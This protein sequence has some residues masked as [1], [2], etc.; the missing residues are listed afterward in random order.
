MNPSVD[1]N[2]CS[3]CR[4]ITLQRLSTTGFLHYDIADLLVSSSK[5]C[6]LCNLIKD[7]LL[8]TS[9]PYFDFS[10]DISIPLAEAQIQRDRDASPR[11]AKFTTPI[12]LRCA[13]DRAGGNLPLVSPGEL[14]VSGLN[15]EAV[16]GLYV[17]KGIRSGPPRG[18]VY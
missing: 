6:R 4:Q 2:P 3:M 18:C 10:L 14:L 11:N 13:I 17:D 7:A 1:A 15:C 16:I 9:L 8:R 12:T 5:G